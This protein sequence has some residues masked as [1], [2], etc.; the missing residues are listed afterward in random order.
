MN[1]IKSSKRGLFN[2]WQ[3]RP[4][5]LA[6]SAL[7]LTLSV[8]MLS[9][10][11]GVDERGDTGLR[12]ARGSVVQSL[13]LQ[14]S[15]VTLV[16]NTSDVVDGLRQFV[17][18]NEDVVAASVTQPNGYSIASVG[19]SAELSLVKDKSTITH[20]RVPVFKGDTLWGNVDVVFKPTSEWL[21]TL[22]WYAFIALGCFTAY[23]L[24]FKRAL[25]QLD[26]SRAVPGRV[27]S[28]FNLFNEG[29]IILDDN[30]NIVM[31]NSAAG[32]LVSISSDNLVGKTLDSWP[33]VKDENWKSPWAE[34][35]MSGNPIVDKPLRLTLPDGSIGVFVTSCSSVGNN[36]DKR[37]VLV[38][39]DDMTMYERQ[40][41]ELEK[42]ETALLK[43][44][45]SLKVKNQ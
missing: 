34:T 2:L 16:G 44:N 10:V 40:N 33:W 14:L 28:A 19:S 1:K 38:T 18:S 39:L 30:Q 4:F 11:L 22:I 13:A 27:D 20:L 7:M 36:Q 45:D 35:L 42:K 6:L 24:F 17:S 32:K 23:I 26:P 15:T 41:I 12:E 5:R 29:V 25:V 43:L 3:S 8:I 21:S 37:G 9:G 31:A